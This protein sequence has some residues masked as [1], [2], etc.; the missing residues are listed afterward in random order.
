MIIL[1]YRAIAEAYDPENVNALDA[2]ALPDQ[3]VD[4]LV[5]RSLQMNGNRLRM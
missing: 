1:A 3:M 2:F 4:P 5:P